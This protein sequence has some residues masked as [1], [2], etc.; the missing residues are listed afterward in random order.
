MPGCGQQG[1]EAS[2]QSA[3]RPALE[4]GLPCLWTTAPALAAWGRG[5]RTTLRAR[6]RRLRIDTCTPP[7]ANPRARHKSQGR[8]AWANTILPH[9]NL[10][11]NFIDVPLTFTVVPASAGQ[12]MARPC[13]CGLSLFTSSSIRAVPGDWTAFPAPCSRTA[14]LLLSTWKR[15]H[16]RPQTPR[17]STPSRL[18]LGGC[19]SVL[20]L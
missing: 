17:P 14:L 16:L 10:F 7:S 1:L 13:V 19:K 15:L 2:T 18:P 12:Q 5:R 11:E 8:R 9:G 3:L 20:C 4:W 6:T